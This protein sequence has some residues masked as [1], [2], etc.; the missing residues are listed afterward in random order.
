MLHIDAERVRELRHKTGAGMMNCKKAL[1]ESNGN[2]EEAIKSL[3]EKGQASADKKVNRKTIEGLV[4]SYIHIGGRIGV[5]IEVNCET[6]FVARR[7]EFQELVQNLAMQIAAS[8]DVL[9]IQNDDIP[10]DIISN[11]KAIESGKED[12][13]NKPDDIREKIIL[14]R[15]DKTL[16]NLTLLNQPFIRDANITVD[17]LIKEKISLFGENIRIKRFTRYTLG[18]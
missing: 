6:D 3:R 9:Y 11:E 5:L 8:P 2:F 7:E 10:E 16:K 1:L 15:I 4:N 12:L 18:N 13:S 14:G 17:E